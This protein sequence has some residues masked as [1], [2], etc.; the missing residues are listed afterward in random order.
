MFAR[1]GCPSSSAHHTNKSTDRHELTNEKWQ[2]LS[3]KRWLWDQ[4]LH[5][6][7]NRVA[8]LDSIGIVRPNFPPDT[9]WQ[10][11]WSHAPSIQRAQAALAAAANLGAQRCPTVPPDTP[12]RSTGW[13]AGHFLPSRRG[14]HTQRTAYSAERNSGGGICLSERDGL[15][16]RVEVCRVDRRHQVACEVEPAH[17]PV[18]DK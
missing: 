3:P 15:V 4:V 2:P 18:T 5:R 11:G 9:R 7:Q 14:R 16:E 6:H 17:P 8:L 10:R 12:V 13:L 1:A